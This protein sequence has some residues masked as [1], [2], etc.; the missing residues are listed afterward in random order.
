M[1]TVRAASLRVVLDSNVYISAFTHP[2][3]LPSQVWRQALQ[4]RYTLLI[5]PAIVAEVARVLRLKFAWNDFHIIRRMKLLT[6]VAE[7]VNPTITLYI[8]NDDPSDD[9]ILE[10]AVSGQADLIVSSDHHLT[11]LKSF[12][13]ISIIR[14][15]D[16]HRTLGSGTRK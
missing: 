14:P 13:G 15:V 7:I 5:S 3:G 6:R 9:R 10:C 12:R 16:L 2:Q 8:I 11:N 1:S 4:R